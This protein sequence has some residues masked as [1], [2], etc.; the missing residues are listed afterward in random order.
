MGSPTGRLSGDQEITNPILIHTSTAITGCDGQISSTSKTHILK[1]TFVYTH[2]NDSSESEA[3]S[4]QVETFF[5]RS[6]WYLKHHTTLSSRQGPNLHETVLQILKG[7][8]WTEAK[9]VE[10]WN[11][12][13]I[14]PFSPAPCNLEWWTEEP[15]AQKWSF[16]FSPQ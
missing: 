8:N 2:H 16:K 5:Y 14:S 10:K 1:N 13:G 12:L 3:L 11:Q 15:Q 7:Q 6:W 4:E 9:F